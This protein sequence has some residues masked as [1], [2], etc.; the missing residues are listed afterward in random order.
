[1]PFMMAKGKAAKPDAIWHSN[2]RD[3][4]A[5]RED[6]PR[7]TGEAHGQAAEHR[8]SRRAGGNTVLGVTISKPDKV[9]WPRARQGKAVT[10]LDLARYLEAVGP[11]MIEH[12]EGRPCSLIRAPDGIEGKQHFFQRHAMTGMS[13]LRAAR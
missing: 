2:K 7:A 13:E 4:A 5:S 9:L 3:G 11:W 1:M 12:I 10:K 6:M 8:H